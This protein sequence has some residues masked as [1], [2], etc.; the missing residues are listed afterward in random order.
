MKTTL[1]LFPHTAPQGSTI[2]E[3]PCHAYRISI[4]AKGWDID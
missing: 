4:T 2:V 1:P 3:G